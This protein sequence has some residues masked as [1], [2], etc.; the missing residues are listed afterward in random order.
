MVETHVSVSAVI[1]AYFEEKTIASV[2]ERCLPYVNE[3]VVVNDGSTDNT[4]I[5]AQRAGARVIEQDHN[6]G[7]RETR[8]EILVTLDADNQ[9]DPTEIPRLIQPIIDGDADL[10]MGERQYFPHLSEK[11]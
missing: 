8:G 11:I 4:T 9:H 5:N 1:P 2:V 3:V 10:V 6:M 7:L